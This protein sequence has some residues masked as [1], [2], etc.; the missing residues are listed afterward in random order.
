MFLDGLLLSIVAVTAY[1]FE[2]ESASTE[3]GKLEG[4]GIEKGMLEV[5]LAVLRGKVTVYDTMSRVQFR[6]DLSAIQP[7][8]DELLSLF[9]ALCT[10]TG[11]LDPY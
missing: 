3:G 11:P 9:T 2:P 4:T 10:L 7:A 8:L 1:R 5:L 6:G